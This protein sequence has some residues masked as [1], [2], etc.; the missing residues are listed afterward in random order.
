MS[1]PLCFCFWLDLSTYVVIEALPISP[2]AA[3]LTINRLSPIRPVTMETWKQSWLQVTDSD[4]VMS[5]IPYCIYTETSM[6]RTPMARLP[7]LFRTLS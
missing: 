7:R 5:E 6:A 4:H 1:L 3:L 2:L